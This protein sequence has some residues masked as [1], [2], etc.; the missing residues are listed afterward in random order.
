M[1]EYILI[2]GG[3]AF[4]SA[5]QPGPLMAFLFSSVVRKGW[6]HTLPASLAPLIS[7]GPIALL[8]LLALT[9]IP[10]GM[11]RALQAAGGLFL[12]WLAW[13]TWRK[14]RAGAD[15]VPAPDHSPPRTMMQA[16]TVNLLNPNPYIGWSL[17][18]GPAAVKAWREAPANAV[19]LIGSFYAVMIASLA[20]L[21][22]VFGTTRFLGPGGRRA[23][24]LVSALILAALGVYR[25]V[26]SVFP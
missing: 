25:V 22:V 20:C 19:A 26:S 12:V 17:V 10:H 18:L 6:Q 14:W 21:I 15:E 1:L 9:R 8:A 2:G 23:L 13:A 16:V 7:D 24:V 4:A 11:S 5:V 3:F